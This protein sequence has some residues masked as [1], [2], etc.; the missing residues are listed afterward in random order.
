MKTLAAEPQLS[1]SGTREGRSERTPS[2]AASAR[3][4]PPRESESPEFQA[5][6]TCHEFTPARVN[7]LNVLVPE[8]QEDCTQMAWEDHC[9][10]QRLPE[11]CRAQTVRVPDPESDH[12]SGTPSRR[13]QKL[14]V[15]EASITSPV[16]IELQPLAHPSVEPAPQ[17]GLQT[18]ACSRA[19]VTVSSLGP[20]DKS[21]LPSIGGPRQQ[22]YG[23]VCVYYTIRIIPPKGPSLAHTHTHTHTHSH[24]Y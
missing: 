15:Q 13:V 7:A 21:K 14:V 10:E 23:V 4:L 18:A 20:T 6:A 16:N 11:H 17:P 22:R 2:P 3:H 24:T 8:L 5:M 19:D 1:F 12:I 9:D